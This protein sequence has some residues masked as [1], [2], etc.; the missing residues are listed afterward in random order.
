[1]SRAITISDKI[2]REAAAVG[3]SL[4]SIESL[5]QTEIIRRR[6][7]NVENEAAADSDEE[8]ERLYLRQMK[9]KFSR[10]VDEW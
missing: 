7:Q 8:K 4:E 9:R 2:E 6:G 10:I 1:M 5:I 3:I